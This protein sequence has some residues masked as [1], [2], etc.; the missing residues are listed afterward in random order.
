MTAPTLEVETN[1]WLEKAKALAP[2]IA[3]HRDEGERQRHLA[4]PIYEAMREAG[5]FKLWQPKNLGGEEEDIRTVLMVVEQLARYDGPTAWNLLIGIQ[6]GYLLGFMDQ[7][8]AAEMLAGE[9][10]ATLGGSGQ[11]GG[12]ATPVEGGYRISGRWSFMSGV[13]H[14]RWVCGNTIMLD[15]NGEERKNEDGSPVFYMCFFRN[16]QYEIIDTWHTTGLRGTGSHDV[17]VKEAFVPEKRKI[18]GMSIHSEHQSGPLYHTRIPLLLGPPLSAV[19]LGIAAEAIDSFAELAGT[20]VPSR[21]QR[22]L[23]ENDFVQMGLG[24]A[25]AKVNAGRAYLYQAMCDNL[26]PAMVAGNGDSEEV[27]I[28]VFLSSV[29]A[30]QSAA[31]AVDILQGLAGTTGIYEGHPIERAFRDVH[32]VTQHAGSAL[33]NY[34]RGGAFKLGLGFSMQR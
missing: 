19:G 8:T 11:R 10:D 29:N 7:P 34:S 15:E 14:K 13:H 30:A 2:I 22:R 16:D 12:R 9:P 25:M 31:E 4:T 3:E 18:A 23:A 17:E 5:L 27:A 28:D 21:S 24:K 20:K 26:W 33:T 6:S 32:M 1:V